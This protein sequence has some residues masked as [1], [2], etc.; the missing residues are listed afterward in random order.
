V[1]IQVGIVSTLAEQ[2]ELVSLALACAPGCIVRYAG[3]D[4]RVWPDQAPWPDVAVF[5]LQE[6]PKP[7]RSAEGWRDLSW[8]RKAAPHV[9]LCLWFQ[10]AEPEVIRAAS[11]AGVK[12][13]VQWGDATTESWAAM[14]RVVN[15]GGSYWSRP[16]DVIGRWGRE[17]VVVP[18]PSDQRPD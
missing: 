8:L 11:E 5:G 10:N 2:R 13:L 9:R 15:A 17:A 1:D 14:V 6:I 4:A 16:F 7:A 18:S 12:G 3:A